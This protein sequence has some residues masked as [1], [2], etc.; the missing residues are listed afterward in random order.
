[1]REKYYDEDACPKTKWQER[2]RREL[3]RV[4]RLRKKNDDRA[5]F[6][7]QQALG[8][9]MKGNFMSPSKVWPDSKAK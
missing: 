3:R 6:G 7:A 8:W 4:D 1:M 9:A 5:L 2:I